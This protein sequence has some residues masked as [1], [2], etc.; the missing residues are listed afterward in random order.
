[1]RQYCFKLLCCAL[2][3]FALAADASNLRIAVASNFVPVLEALI[4]EVP[5]PSKITIIS[6]ATGALS[7]QILMGAPFDVLLAADK[8]RPTKLANLNQLAAP[9][10][11][12][13]GQLVL[14][15]AQALTDLEAG[16]RIAI[17]NPL[18]APYGRA[19]EEVLQRA[20]IPTLQVIQGNNAQQAYQFKASGNVNFALVPASLAEGI[21]IPSDWYSPIKQFAVSVRPAGHTNHQSAEAFLLWLSSD[22]VQSRLPQYGYSR[23]QH[24]S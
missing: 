10:C 19:A 18:T 6:G 4:Q 24:D 7:N 17:A 9:V 11:Y 22:E 20:N 3:W 14:M 21:V 23:C 12:A 13:Q 15:G 5:P 8:E 16:G 2:S 1:M